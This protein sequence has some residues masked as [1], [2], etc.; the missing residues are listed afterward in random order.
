MAGILQAIGRRFGIGAK[1]SSSTGTSALIWLGPASQ[2][3]PTLA[4]TT[5]PTAFAINSWVYSCVSEIMGAT[6]SAPLKVQTKRGEDWEDTKATP[7]G[8]LLDY[9]NA[10]E[11]QFA[12]IEATAGWL[13]LF[14][15]AFWRLISS[16][17]GG[18][19]IAIQVL[20][21]H[22]VS[23]R[24]GQGKRS[25]VI[26][27]YTLRADNGV[28]TEFDDTE[29]VHFKLFGPTDPAF[30]M[31]PIRVLETKI[32]AATAADRFNYAF[33]KGGG[34]PTAVLISERDL[35][36]E[37][38]KEY[39]VRYADWRAQSRNDGRP[40]V[41]D[42]GTRL[43]V[44]GTNPDT[45]TVTELPKILREDICAVF[46]VPPAVVG[47]LEYAN[48]SNYQEQRNSFYSKT[49]QRYWRRIC[50]ALNE[51]LVPLFGD[52]IQVIFDTSAIE[53]MQPDFLGKASAI[54]SLLKVMCVDE[55]R[56]GLF[57]LP[58][59]G[60]AYGTG[61]WGGFNLVQLA[62]ANGN[63]VGYAS[64]AP[65][66]TAP[67][68][69]PAPAPPTEQPSPELP[70]AEPA[71]P[72]ML[73][74]IVR[75]QPQPKAKSLRRLSP[76]GRAALLRRF[77]ATRD[78]EE[79]RLAAIVAD[80]FEG[81]TREV[82][83]NLESSKAHW[84]GCIKVPGMDAL[85]FDLEAS[86]TDLGKDIYPALHDL[87]DRTGQVALADLTT[88]VN[89]TLENPRARALLEARK[90]M[91][92]TVA[93]TAQDSCRASLA[94]GL[95]A[96]DNLDAMRERIMQWSATGKDWQAENVARTE[97]N[98]CMNEA[99]REGYL[100][101][102]AAGVEW[103]AGGPP[104]DREWHTAVDGH[105]ITWDELFQLETGQF[106][107][108]GDPSMGPEDVCG[109]RCCTSPVIDSEMPVPIETV[110]REPD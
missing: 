11:D 12:L 34:L 31:S 48:F 40:L 72:K 74:A 47:I 78:T 89:W 66:V 101:G 80:W 83:A 107:G 58:P 75:V 69:K 77:N 45:V 3:Y 87:Y 26:A 49:V 86:G 38:A 97:T 25:G 23:I 56:H 22:Q 90:L 61:Y 29:V 7:L 64:G 42:K 39:Q 92:K 51:Q 17:P 33:Y 14:G 65:T 108:P 41:T 1:A 53:A 27:G 44:P 76:Q 54:D 62:D 102:G 106:T 84:V 73:P 82:L 30:G 98:I 43:E 37:Q 105:I 68:P 104:N 24:P 4:S 20:P 100:Q 32:N 85:L 36:P 94:E 5:D 52:G 10:S 2:T 59:I 91:M 18:K 81:I 99:A 50:S 71:A 60:G 63:T 93:R 96:G 109:C 9:V 6:A 19:P 28:K 8:T 95:L 70:P 88:E 67:S 103:L 21:A 13:A 79:K 35:T 16:K 55:V 57:G 110:P 46:G 15:N